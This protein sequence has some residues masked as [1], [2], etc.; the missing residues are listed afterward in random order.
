MAF[1]A[2]AAL[3]GWSMRG[4]AANGFARATEFAGLS[5]FPA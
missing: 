5:L 4:K 1:I 3:P 2:F